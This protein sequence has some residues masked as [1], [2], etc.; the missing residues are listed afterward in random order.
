MVDWG[1]WAVALLMAAGVAGLLVQ[2][3]RRGHAEADAV[4]VDLAVYKD[5]L[6]EVERDRARGTLAADEAARLR[7]EIGRRVLDLDRAAAPVAERNAVPVLP[8]ALGLG[9]VLLGGSVG[10]Y[11]YLGAPG[12][13]DLPIARRIA[14][15]EELMASRPGQAEAVAAAP[16]AA[17]PTDLDPAYKELIEKLRLAVAE[18]PDDPRGLELLARNEAALGQYVA[19]E[20]AQRQLIAVKDAT[21]TSAD[22]AAL[23]EIMVA[24]AGGYVSP[25]AETA[26]TAALVLDPTDP[27]ARYY[28]GLMFIQSGR[29]D[30]GFQLW[31]E[32]LE[33]GPQ[34]A[35]W[36][37][38]L[39][40]EI[41][42]V[43]WRAGVDYAV[44]EAKG[45]SAGDI[46]AAADMAPDER[47]AMIEGMVAQLSERLASDGGD[48]EDWERLIRSLG[49]LERLD[50]AQ[51][52]Y[53][54]AKVKFEG[55]PAELSFLRQAAAETGLNP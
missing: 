44:P 25:E 36:M 9:L 1:F 26:L 6:A 12:Y 41:G 20:A 7:A 5:Q 43:A 3:L 18:N 46:A 10:A 51:A 17:E 40:A 55:Q 2:A 27:L 21:A 37:D 24:A 49:V 45:P 29:Y 32:L 53:D 14:M 34:D 48:V 22:H 30:R 8:L 38:I 13:P 15:S 42:D 52:I 35:P 39:R 19:A 11:W 33:N 50:E 23:A 47:Q 16:E 4:A 54:E 28:A 31:R